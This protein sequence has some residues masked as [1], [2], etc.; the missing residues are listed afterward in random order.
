MSHPFHVGIMGGGLYGYIS[1]FDD[2]FHLLIP[3][4]AFPLIVST[5]Q[6][7]DTIE[8]SLDFESCDEDITVLSVITGN[9]LYLDTNTSD[10]VLEAIIDPSYV[11]PVRL[12]FVVEDGH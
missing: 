5:S 1:D 8:F 4:L 12:R 7:A 9:N 10:T 11:G 6:C 3:I 2:D